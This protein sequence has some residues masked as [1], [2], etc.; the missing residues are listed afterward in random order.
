MAAII[1]LH[2]GGDAGAPALFFVIT[3]VAHLNQ[4][5]RG[6]EELLR[7][8]EI[9]RMMRYQQLLQTRARSMASRTCCHGLSFWPQ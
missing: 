9:S 6:A 4:S 7:V 1:Y 8:P 5:A 2:A 3:F